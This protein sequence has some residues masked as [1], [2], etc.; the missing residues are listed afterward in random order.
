MYETDQN[1][2][3]FVGGRQMKLVDDWLLGSNVALADGAVRVAV[4]PSS[5]PPL[6]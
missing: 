5:S 6:S 4:I 1:Q 3:G 2:F